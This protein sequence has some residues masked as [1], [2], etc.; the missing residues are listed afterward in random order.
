MKRVGNLWNTL[1]NKQNAIKAIYEGTEKKRQTYQVKRVL[2]YVDDNP[3]HQGKLDPEKVSAYAER[4]VASLK[5]GWMPS[6]QFIRHL[7][8]AVRLTVQRC[9]T[10]LYTG[11]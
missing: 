7:A 6:P 2:G 4:Q 10:I 8:R 11:C 1:C 5:N 3:E 9:P